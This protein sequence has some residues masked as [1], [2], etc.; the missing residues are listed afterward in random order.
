MHLRV[1]LYFRLETGRRQLAKHKYKG[2]RL[3][4]PTGDKGSPKQYIYVQEGDQGRKETAGK[5]AVTHQESR[6]RGSKTKHNT[7]DYENKTGNQTNTET[8][9]QDTQT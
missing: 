3:D 8:V 7:H 5:T 2:E 6:D 1:S 4:A 9:T